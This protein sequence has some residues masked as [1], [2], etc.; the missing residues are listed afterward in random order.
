M[1][2]AKVGGRAAAAVADRFERW[3]ADLDP[4]ALDQFCWTIREHSLSLPIVYFADWVD[5][6]L[7]A[8]EVPGPDALE[9]RRFQLTVMTPEQAVDWADRLRKQFPEQ[10]WFAYRLREAAE[11]WSL[12]VYQ[13]VIVSIRE[14]TGVST[15]D[16]EIRT[17]LDC[18][19]KWLDQPE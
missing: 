8:D 12:V 18:V 9:G 7:M 19:P 16:D 11:A 5:R 15:G 13:C 17:A 3:R 14:V 6:W 2:L 10:E 4:E 1:T